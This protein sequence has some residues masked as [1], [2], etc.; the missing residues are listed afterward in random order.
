MTLLQNLLEN[1]NAHKKAIQKIEDELLSYPNVEIGDDLS[2]EITDKYGKNIIRDERSWFPKITIYV[3]NFNEKQELFSL[4][5][6]NQIKEHCI[7][8]EL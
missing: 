2:Q 1:Y 8:D 6:N 7:F 4:I 5:V 3:E